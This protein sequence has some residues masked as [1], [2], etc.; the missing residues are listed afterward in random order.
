MV[1]S[2][3]AQPVIRV[4]DLKNYVH[5]PRFPYYEICL[6]DVRPRTFAMD[7]GKEAHEIEWARARRRTLSAYG[8]PKGKRCFNVRLFDPARGLSGMID[9]LVIA[10]PETPAASAFVLYPVDYKLSTK[11]TAAFEL[12]V[13]AYALLLETAYAVPVTRGYV[14]L[15]GQRQL[16]P[17]EVTAARRA[18]VETALE[19]IRKMIQ[20]E[21]MPPPVEHRAKCRACEWRR[22]CN[23]VI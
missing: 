21:Q 13:C 8:L 11:I 17:V 18:A 10:P 5:C 7:A 15:I 19:A 12:Q 23:D 20:Q 3:D 16:Y 2:I 14:Y 22:F 1:N 6:S 9:E 4:T